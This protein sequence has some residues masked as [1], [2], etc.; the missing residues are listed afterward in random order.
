MTQQNAVSRRIEK[1][2]KAFTDKDYETCLLHLFPAIDATGKARRPTQG[3]G[4]RI[5]GFLEDQE[6]IISFVA[7]RSLFTGNSVDG[8]TLAQALYNFGR[9][10]IAHE[11]QLDPRL[12]IIEEGSI[13]ASKD[14]WEISSGFIMG[15]IIAVISAKENQDAFLVDDVTI[16]IHGTPFIINDTWGEEDNVRTALFR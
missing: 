12:K 6:D 16:T 13:R 5:R 7:L 4:K 11:G 14:N 8:Q 3:V 10:S 1:A 9:T 2:I 15:M